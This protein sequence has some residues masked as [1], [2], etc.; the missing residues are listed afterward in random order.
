MRESTKLPAPRRLSQRTSSSCRCR[1]R[2]AVWSPLRHWVRFIARSRPAWALADESFRH[3]CRRG[4]G[5]RYGDLCEVASRVSLTST[6]APGRGL[7]EALCEVV[8]DVNDVTE[9]SAHDFQPAGSPPGRSVTPAATRSLSTSTPRSPAHA[10]GSPAPRSATP[11]ANAT[12]PPTASSTHHTRRRPPRHCQRTLTGGRPD[13]ALDR[14]EHPA[15]DPP[16]NHARVGR[17]AR[18]PRPRHDTPRAALAAPRGERSQRERRGLNARRTTTRPR[19][20]RPS[21]QAVPTPVPRRRR[22]GDRGSLLSSAVDVS[23]R[24]KPALCRFFRT[25]S[26][27]QSQRSKSPRQ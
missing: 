2:G 16:H 3:D 24:S 8:N 9:L 18:Q 13:R 21:S 10:T 20:A 11:S 23:R 25:S 15:P 5:D 26:T 27:R 17:I 12:S 14:R 22:R 6:R 1:A 4:A 7:L 19:P